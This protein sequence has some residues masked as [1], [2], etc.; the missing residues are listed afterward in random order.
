MGILEQEILRQAVNYLKN[1]SFYVM[2]H[3][4]AGTKY[5]CGRKHPKGICINIAIT[6]FSG[7]SFVD[8][9]NLNMDSFQEF[10]NEIDPH[11]YIGCIPSGPSYYY[12]WVF[13]ELTETIPD[14]DVTLNALGGG[15][16]FS[17][18]ID[19]SACPKEFIITVNKLIQALKQLN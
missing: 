9:D 14:L 1:G 5:A 2:N 11:L 18:T 3:K 19:I 15:D 17:E 7:K 8:S 4:R 13:F 6:P 12:F 10:L 16:K